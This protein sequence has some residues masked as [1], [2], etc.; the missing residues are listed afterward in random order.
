MKKCILLVSENIGLNAGL[1]VVMQYLSN[2][3][4][5]SLRCVNHHNA[6]LYFLI[7]FR[8]RANKRNFANKGLT[9]NLN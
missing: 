7:G 3:S 8:N 6:I 2:A 5:S 1:K 9:L 4:E